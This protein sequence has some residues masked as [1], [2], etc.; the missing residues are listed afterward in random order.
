LLEGGDKKSAAAAMTAC[1]DKPHRPFGLVLARDAARYRGMPAQVR[2]REFA[3]L[4]QR[5][6]VAPRKTS[7]PAL[8][9]ID[10]IDGGG[11][12]T[13][14]Q[15]KELIHHLWDAPAL[16]AGARMIQMLGGNTGAAIAAAA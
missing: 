10:L 4:A 6:A 15:I 1:F 3:S 9:L 11:P 12:F 16:A 8:D 5:Y 2:A 13:E 14:D 7:K